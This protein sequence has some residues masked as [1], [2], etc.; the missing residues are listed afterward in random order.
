MP[1]TLLAHNSEF[2]CSPYLHIVRSHVVTQYRGTGGG[3]VLVPDQHTA[4]RNFD[5]PRRPNIVGQI[6][7]SLC[8]GMYDLKNV[9]TC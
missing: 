6:V 1:L 2:Y 4:H 8:D 3:E 9:T 7:Q 5:A